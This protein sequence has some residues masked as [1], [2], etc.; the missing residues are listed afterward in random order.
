MTQLD[1]GD[2]GDR[3]P[4]VRRLQRAGKQRVFFD[5]LRR[6]FRIDARRPREYQA[7]DPCEMSGVNDIGLNRQI[8]N[9][10]P[11]NME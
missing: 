9:T 8:D 10:E 1:P 4:F 2:F 3:V 6:E 5:G 7:V 11:S